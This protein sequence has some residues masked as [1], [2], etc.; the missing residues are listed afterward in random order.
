VSG[1]TQTSGP[2]TFD[3]AWFQRYYPE[4]SEWCSPDQA[5]GYFNLATALLDNRD[6]GG[7]AP[8]CESL[9]HSP[10][11]DIATRQRLLGLLTA[12]FAALLAP[13]NGVASP[14]M[15]GRITSASEGSVSVS[16]EFPAVAGAEWFNQTK[17]GAMF[18]QL[19]KRFS[20]MRYY[21]SR[22]PFQRWGWPFGG[23]Y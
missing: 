16:T 9:R 14:T 3:Y 21:P 18:W 12:H 7:S 4:I 22:R 6:G 8:F 10:V 17:Y 1:A 11:T 2:V 19:T 23:T 5:E 20:M 13:I 15:V